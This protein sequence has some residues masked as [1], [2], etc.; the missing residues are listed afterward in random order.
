[1]IR[2]SPFKNYFEGEILYKGPVGG[3]NDVL[4]FFFSFSENFSNFVPDILHYICNHVG[5]MNCKRYRNWGCPLKE[6]GT[7]APEVVARSSKPNTLYY[8]KSFT[9][10]FNSQMARVLT[11]I[12]WKIIF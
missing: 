4:Q 3:K 2:S 8:S 6:V 10:F 1:M 12:S 7:M 11:Q 5:M 9:I